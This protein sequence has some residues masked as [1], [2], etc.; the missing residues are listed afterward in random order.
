MLEQTDLDR[1][2]AALPPAGTAARYMRKL[3]EANEEISRAYRGGTLRE[4]KLAFAVWWD[5]NAQWATAE[6]WCELA[7]QSRQHAAECRAK[8]QKGETKP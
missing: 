7:A 6:G 8:A 4:L 2:C 5:V 3:A 1:H